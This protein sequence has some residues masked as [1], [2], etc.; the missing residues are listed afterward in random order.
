MVANIQQTAKADEPPDIP[1]RSSADDAHL[2]TGSTI[3]LTQR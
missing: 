2:H 1:Q 3:Q